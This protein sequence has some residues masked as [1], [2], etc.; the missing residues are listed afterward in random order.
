MRHSLILCLIVNFCV[1]FVAAQSSSVV[2]AKTI[3][4]GN[5]LYADLDPEK[6]QYPAQSAI[7]VSG[8][9]LYI[10]GDSIC[11]KGT[12]KWVIVLHDQKPY[13]IEKILVENASHVNFYLAEMDKKGTDWRQRM[14]MAD[15][16][17]IQLSKRTEEEERDRLIKDSLEL[18]RQIKEQKKQADSLGQIVDK[19]FAELRI[20]NLIIYEWSWS[21]ES[22]YSLAADFSIRFI[23]PFRKKIKYL[24]ITLRA[25]NPVDDPI[26]D[27]VSGKL[28]K[29]VQAIGP[30]EYEG[31]GS[32]EFENVWYS[33]VIGWMKISRLKVQFFDGSIKIIENPKSLR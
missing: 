31:E 10:I 9:I 24:W 15:P 14:V 2:V 8:R 13:Y 1:Y 6:C 30:I 12:R 21:Y 23:N 18:V 7:E 17:I 19:M 5:H 33:R 25:Y 11:Q 27:G 26:R 22:E 16:E 20:K 28:E 29:T 3:T 4:S 32:Y